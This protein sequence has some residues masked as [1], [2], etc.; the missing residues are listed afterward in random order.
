MKSLDKHFP[1]LAKLLTDKFSIGDLL[2]SCNEIGINTLFID[3]INDEWP[4]MNTIVSALDEIGP[5]TVYF[6]F[7]DSDWDI[8]A[9]GTDQQFRKLYS[10]LADPKYT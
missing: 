9:I 1:E 2:D 3:N 5:K 10:H 4:D 6:Q 8:V 7:G